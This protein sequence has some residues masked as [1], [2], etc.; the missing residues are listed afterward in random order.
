MNSSRWLLTADYIG[1]L[2]LLP[3]P[4]THWVIFNLDCFPDPVLSTAPQ[5]AGLAQVRE[6]CSLGWV[7]T[8]IQRAQRF[9]KLVLPPCNPRR[10]TT[11]LGEQQRVKRKQNKG[12]KQKCTFFCTR[13]VFPE[14]DQLMNLF[15]SKCTLH[16]WNRCSSPAKYLWGVE[17]PGVYYPA[18]PT[19]A[20]VPPAFLSKAKWVFLIPSLHV[21]MVIYS[22]ALLTVPV[23]LCVQLH[24]D[25]GWKVSVAEE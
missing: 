6:N 18:Q 15:F 22:R 24:H 11:A 5:T 16:S 2:K 9:L 10:E 17:L 1:W 12:I 14:E 21:L 13:G 23:Q 20:V 8:N 25:A 19:E 4:A 7:V 3:S